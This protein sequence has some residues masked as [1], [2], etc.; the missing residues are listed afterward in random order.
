MTVPTGKNSVSFIK[1]DNVIANAAIDLIRAG[2]AIQRVV[3]AEAIEDVFFASAQ[4][5]IRR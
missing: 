3:A 2:A 4:Q 1:H 5:R